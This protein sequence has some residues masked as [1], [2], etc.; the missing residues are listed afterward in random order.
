MAM[1]RVTAKVDGIHATSGKTLVAGEE[2]DIDEGEFGDEVFER[3]PGPG[4]TLGKTGITTSQED[5]T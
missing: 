3:A 5:K 2:C 4:K 1:I